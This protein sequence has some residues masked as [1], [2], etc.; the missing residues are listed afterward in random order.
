MEYMF[1]PIIIIL[2]GASF[3]LLL[4]V[5]LGRWDEYRQRAAIN[6]NIKINPKMTTE[7]AYPSKSLFHFPVLKPLYFI[8]RPFYEKLAYLKNLKY[9]AE[10]L[11]ISVDIE[12]LIV[13]KLLISVLLGI[14]T[15]L[16]LSPA[17]SLIGMALGFFLPDII[18]FQRVKARKEEITRVFPESIDLLDMCIN[19]GADF[20][21]AIRWLIAKSDYNPFIEQLN[22]VLGE[23]QIGKPRVNALKDMAKRLNIRDISSF[24]RTVTQAERMGTSIEDAFKNLSEDTRNMRFEMGERYAIKASIKILFPLIFCI[25]PAIMIIVAGPII[26]KFSQGNLIPTTETVTSA[27]SE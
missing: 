23:I 6:K 4:Y 9:Q 18:M 14:L 22:I 1:N 15:F 13:I 20:V 24:V 7:T 11:M 8:S 2:L 25:M 27:P 16:F 26:L 21:S 10:V 12:G 3:F 19:A 5:L 17:Y